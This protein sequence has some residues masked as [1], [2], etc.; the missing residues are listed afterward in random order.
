MEPLK[1]VE[2][3]ES[4]WHYHLSETGANGK[5]SLCGWKEVMHTDIPLN[6]WGRKPYA[7]YH[8]AESFCKK[9]D[10]IYQHLKEMHGQ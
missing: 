1:I 8:I 2:G 6:T 7:G 3:A 10:K 9:C 4:V 5:P